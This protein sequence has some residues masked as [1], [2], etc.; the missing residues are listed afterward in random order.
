MNKKYFLC[1]IWAVL[2]F[3]AGGHYLSDTTYYQNG[4][5]KSIGSDMNGKREGEWVFYYPEGTISAFFSY[6]AG[7]LHGMQIYLIITGIS[8]LRKI[9]VMGIWKTPHIIII[10]TVI[11]RSMECIPI[12]NTRENGDFMIR[13]GI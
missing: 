12:P 13:K 8:Q 2:S 9:G 3:N 7:S 5:I 10:R 11:W 4:T 1:W 6:A